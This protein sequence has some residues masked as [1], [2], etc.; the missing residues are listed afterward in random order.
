MVEI[1]SII[2]FL[3]F[4][5][6][7]F[8]TFHYDENQ[9]SENLAFEFIQKHQK[10]PQI[11][12]LRSWIQRMGNDRSAA[13]HYFRRER[14]AFALPPSIDIS[15]EV[16]SLRWYCLRINYKSV[17][18]FM[19]GDKTTRKPEDCPNVAKPFKEANILSKHIFKHIDQGDLLTTD[20]D[21][22]DLG[23]NNSF[24]IYNSDETKH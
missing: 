9:S 5:E 3:E 2:K 6:V 23:Q 7:T 10:H 24:K 4:K 22:L 11:D 1:G 13:Q 17:I 16:C 18:L 15:K 20:D 14:T 19:G 12:V 21:S 8:Y